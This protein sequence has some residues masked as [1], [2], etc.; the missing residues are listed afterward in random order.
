MKKHLLISM[1]IFCLVKTSSAQNN[2]IN[3]YSDTAGAS[4]QGY[5]QQLISTHDGGIVGLGGSY[6][7]GGDSTLQI[8]KFDSSGQNEWVRIFNV[9]GYFM[10][11]SEII[12]LENH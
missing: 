3:Q 4:L 9:H 1:I 12:E 8:F 10:F 2:F 11:P 7:S 5:F 6:N